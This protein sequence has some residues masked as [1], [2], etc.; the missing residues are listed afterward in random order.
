M[1]RKSYSAEFKA[2]VAL[3]AI[4]NDKTIAEISS[5]YE[6]HPTQIQKWKVELEKQATSIFS[7]ESTV[8][9]CDGKHLLDYERKLGQLTM[10]NDYLKKNLTNYLKK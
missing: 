10:E 5:K 6:V 3:E 8:V 2:K 1:T 7:K 9:E 4:K